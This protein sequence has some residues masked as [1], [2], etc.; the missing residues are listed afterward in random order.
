MNVVKFAY[1]DEFQCTGPECHDSCCKHWHI[2]INKKEYLDYKKMKCSPELRSVIDTAFKRNKNVED[3]SYAE[4]RLKENGDCPFLG[5]D[6]LCRLQKELGEKALSFTCNIFPRLSAKVG[7]D[8]VRLSCSAT[9]CHVTEL[10]MRH[11]EGLQII[12]E[13]YDGKNRLINNGSYSS[14]T[15]LKSWEG[16]PYYWNILNAEIDILQNRSFTIPERMLILGYFCQKADHNIKIGTPE[17]IPV[18]ANM[19]LDNELCGKIAAALKPASSDDRIATNSVEILFNMLTRIQTTDETY[20]EKAFL[21]VTERIEFVHKEENGKP[22]YSFSYT[23]YNRLTNIFRGIEKERSYI[24]ENLLVNIMYSSNPQQGVWTNY[25]VLAVFYN[26]LKICAPAFLAEKYTDGELAVALTYAVKMVV[27]THLV[28]GGTLE[29]F[30][31]GNMNT[32]PY[33]AFLV[34]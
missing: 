14:E 1:Y 15:I 28:E 11:P 7:T 19:L 31:Q 13:E 2:R 8:T 33:A 12:E 16:Y 4:M 6:S 10:L 18:L 30:I 29:D 34:C 3:Y 27:N 22:V 32:L 9:C 26:V 24:I 21:Q 25:F 17:K 23:E 5:E 20:L